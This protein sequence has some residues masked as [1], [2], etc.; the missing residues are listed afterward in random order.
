MRAVGIISEYNPF[1]R[2]HAR[3][4][5]QTRRLAG[6]GAVVCVLS[7]C[8]VQRGECALTDKW[9][10]A[11][12]ALRGGADL[13]LEL[14]T[15]WAVSSAEGFA[16]GGVGLL[17]KTGVVDGLSFGSESGDLEGLTALA[18]TM[19]GEDYGQALRQELTG[20]VPFAQ[21]RQRA[22]ERLLGDRGKLLAGANDSLGVEY[23][24]QAAGRLTPLAVLR[25]GASHDS[26]SQT[27]ET[28]SASLIRSLIGQG[29]WGELDR[30]MDGEDAARLE[31]EGVA[32]MDRVERAVLARLRTMTEQDFAALPDSSQGEG[33]PARLV[34]AA[35]QAGSLAEFYR[36][37]KTRRYAHAR[38]RRLA[39][40]AFLGLR[41]ED[42]QE[43]AYLRVLGL[44][45]RGR[46]LLRE[47]KEKA[48]LP[49]LTKPAR[50]RD[51]GEQAGR[52]FQVE[53]RCTDLYG[54]CF[55]KP[56][57][58]GEEFRRCPVVLHPSSG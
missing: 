19:A 22:A 16:R 18:R 41:S 36:L 31:R 21:A 1:H 23:L 38:L 2:G 37:A 50:I 17:L 54:L 12:M 6:D 57:P 45:D 8:W 4:L 33:L 56:R 51:L 53:C 35:A 43:P 10:R 5:A 49:V 58:S 34:R 48:A 32:S 44:N 13:V 25:Q 52:Q 29:R 30:W 27:G 28:A 26:L 24:R 3:H 55:Q 40:W 42:R 11:E 47:M 9:T 14:P 39:L 46:E 15:P 20:G 7:G